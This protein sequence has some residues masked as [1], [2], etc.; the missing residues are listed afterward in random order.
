M[1]Q[2][3]Y[4]LETILEVGD[5]LVPGHERLHKAPGYE[6]AQ[7]A[8]N[9][10][11]DEAFMTHLIDKRIFGNP[12]NGGKRFRSFHVNLSRVLQKHLPASHRP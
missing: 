6:I 12:Y 10:H 9:E 8:D 1:L 4:C 5:R 2:R 11:D 7:G 3:A